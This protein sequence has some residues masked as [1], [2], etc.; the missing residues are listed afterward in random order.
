[1]AVDMAQRLLD[2]GQLLLVVAD[3]AVV[4]SFVAELAEHDSTEIIELRKAS[5]RRNWGSARAISSLLR[6]T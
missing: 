1:M 6:P 5:L 3:G 4:P 2:D